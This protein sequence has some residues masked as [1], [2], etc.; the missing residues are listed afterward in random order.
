[1]KGLRDAA[2]QHYEIE[3]V[4]R[5]AL[6]RS[7]SIEPIVSGHPGYDPWRKTADDQSP[8]YLR[9][10]GAHSQD[11]HEPRNAR[12]PDAP[13][14]RVSVSAASSRSARKSGR[15]VRIASQSDL[16]PRMLLASA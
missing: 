9:A 7:C 15:R 4:L 8:V 13:L 10:Y 6:S 11:R 3:R 1:L 16:H 14:S 5:T 2:A 12:A